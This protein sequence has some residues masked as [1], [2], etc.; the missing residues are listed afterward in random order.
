LDE[1]FRGVDVGARADIGR[2]V[3]QQAR[4]MGVVVASSDPQELVEL[5]DRVL[6]LHE[7]SLAGELPIAEATSERLA[8]LMSG[9][10]E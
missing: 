1:P 6:V 5:A 9:G 7:G 2:V 3:R 8:V 10:S 4:G